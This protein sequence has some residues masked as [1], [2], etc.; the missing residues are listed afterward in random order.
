MTPAVFVENLSAGY[1]GPPVLR[2]VTFSVDPGRTVC[3]LGPNGGGKTTLFRALLGQLEPASGVVRVAGRP[4]YVAQT[5][6]T[7]LDFPVN[8]LDVALMGTLARGRWWLPPRRADR[9]AARAALERVGLAEQAGTPFGELSGG[10]RQRAL[11][12][13]ALVQDARVLLLDEPL[14]GVDPASATQIDRVFAELRGEDRT[15]LVSSHDVESARAFDLVLCL[16]GRL[17]AARAGARPHHARGHLWPRADR[18]RRHRARPRRNG[19]AP[20]AP[21]R[22]GGA[23]SGIEL[24]A[25]L[26]LVLAGGFCGALGFWVVSERLA[27]GAES[28]SHG[29]LPGLVLAALADAPLLLGAAGGAVVA[30]ALIALA[31]RDPRAG[32][33]TGTAVAVTGLV[34]L[35]ALLA[36]APEAPQ[37][38]E[39]LLFGDPLGVTTGDLAAAA[40]L[41]AAGGVALAV[42]HRPLVASSFDAA[43]ADA[44]GLRPALV[45]FALLGLL[46]AAIA[47]AVQGLGALLVLAVLV[48][49]AVAVRGHART[50]A[51]AM[52]AGAGL[53]GAAGIAGIQL[54]SLAGTAAGASVALVLC[55]AAAAG[56]ILPAR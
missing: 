53:A 20:R 49:P 10:Q 39:E 21:T 41:L 28:L 44:L 46:A 27:Y 22:P 25:M 34:G 45:R 26:E 1:G 2:E 4:A 47:V 7:R 31:V 29:L 19:P 9:A 13:R 14:S 40:A 15:V 37:R 52:L 3:V 30:A 42:L 35:G 6:R 16:H 24:R 32:T 17:R 54:S 48:A 36:L 43:G 50:P 23:L 12:A 38:L 11:L 55:A 33:D 5:E 51:A 18:P 56:A 8:A